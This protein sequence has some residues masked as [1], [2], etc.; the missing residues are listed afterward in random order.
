MKSEV[1]GDA[2]PLIFFAKLDELALL[3][4][5]LGPIAVP[6]AVITEAIDKGM[7]RRRRD[8][9]RIQQAIDDGIIVSLQLTTQ[10]K[11]LAKTLHQ[12]TSLGAGECEVISCASTRKLKA[13]MH[14]KKARSVAVRYSIQTINVTDVLFLALLRRKISLKRFKEVLHGLAIVTGLNAATL[15]E[16]EV[17]A[18]EIAR[19]LQ[20]E[21]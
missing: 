12:N 8:A 16:Q 17:I 4:S 21:E 2:S 14:D 11:F 6:P 18:D 19:Q 20:I 7:Q 13:L 9:A 5:V 3:S 1:I 10:E 15:L